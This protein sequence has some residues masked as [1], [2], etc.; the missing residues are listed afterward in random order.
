MKY[1]YVDTS[2]VC[3]DAG[4]PKIKEVTVKLVAL[5]IV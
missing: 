5:L 1:A 4:V 3:V 2:A